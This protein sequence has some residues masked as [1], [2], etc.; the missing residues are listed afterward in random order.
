MFIPGTD[1]IELESAAS[2]TPWRAAVD[3]CPRD[4]RI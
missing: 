3:A 1:L 4:A 2:L